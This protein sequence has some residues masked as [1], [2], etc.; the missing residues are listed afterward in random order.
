[1]LRLDVLAVKKRPVGVTAHVRVRFR[2]TG[3]VTKQVQVVGRLYLS[4]DL[5]ADRHSWR[6]FGYDVTK[7]DVR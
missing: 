3:S 5:S 4:P 6:I 1:M 2:T 7:G